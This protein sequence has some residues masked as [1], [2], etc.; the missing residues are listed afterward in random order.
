MEP[1]TAK[2]IET[3]EATPS[4]PLT[5]VRVHPAPHGA[6]Q[7][8]TRLFTPITSAESF[9]KGSCR[10]EFKKIKND[11]IIQSSFETISEDSPALPG[12][13]GFVNSVVQAYNQHNHLIIRP[14]DVWFSI[15]AQ[16][17]IYINKNSEELRGMFVAHKGQKALKLFVGGEGIDSKKGTMFGID[18]ASFAYMM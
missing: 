4:Q 16:I 14:E 7:I 18:W 11:H 5:G 15:L 17:N 1:L 3:Q 9:L 10:E 6:I 8:N 2:K 13:N 12:R